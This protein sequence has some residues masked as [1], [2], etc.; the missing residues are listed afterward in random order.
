MFLYNFHLSQPKQHWA[1]SKLCT[2]VIRFMEIET[3]GV[4]EKF[5]IYQFSESKTSLI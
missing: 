1:S 2:R 5:Q 4:V 3:R